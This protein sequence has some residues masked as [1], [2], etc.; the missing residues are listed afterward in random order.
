MVERPAAVKVGERSEIDV[1]TKHAIA[2]VAAAHRGGKRRLAR[3]HET[4]GRHHGNRALG[5]RAA[6]TRT[7]YRIDATPRVGVK[8]GP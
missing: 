4:G 2:E 6:Q 8:D 7:G 3:R 5:E 1:A